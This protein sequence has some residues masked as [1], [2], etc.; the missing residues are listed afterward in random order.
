MVP[1]KRR[2]DAEIE[3]EY[4]EHYLVSVLASINSRF[5]LFDAHLFHDPNGN[6]HIKIIWK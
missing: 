2:S 5:H 4:L 6:F 1:I 3:R